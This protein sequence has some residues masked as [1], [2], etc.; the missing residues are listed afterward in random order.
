MRPGAAANAPTDRA[1]ALRLH[2]ALGLGVAVLLLLLVA[3]GT[4]RWLRQEPPV[5]G[6]PALPD[7]FPAIAAIVVGTALAV[8]LPALLLT[9]VLRRARRGPSHGLRLRARVALGLTLAS[10][11]VFL[12]LQIRDQWLSG[13]CSR[14]LPVQALMALWFP[15]VVLLATTA[16]R[17]AVLD[18]G[19]PGALRHVPRLFAV[20][21][22]VLLVTDDLRCPP[23]QFR[24]IWRFLPGAARGI[25]R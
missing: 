23:P 6:P 4:T 5:E 25:R 22:F 8:G 17:A 12:G 14:L 19:L 15:V 7:L 16:R 18:L 3:V 20:A 24:G 1:L 10:E 9:W 21:L 2:L 13:E 11:A